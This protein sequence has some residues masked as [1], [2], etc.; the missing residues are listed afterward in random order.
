[1]GMKLCPS[2]GSDIEK[3]DNKNMLAVGTILNNRYELGTV[4]SCDNVSVIYIGY[5]RQA[6]I[7]VTLREFDGRAVEGCPDNNNIPVTGEMAVRRFVQY[8]R[9]MA[10]VSLC[11][12]FSRTVEVFE[13]N[14]KGYWVNE[15][16]EGTPLKEILGSDIKISLS[17]AVKITKELCDGLKILHFSHHIFGAI[18]PSSLY[19]QK[20]G[21]VKLFG[22][23]TPYFDFLSDFD[24]KATLLNPSYTAPEV[25]EANSKKGAFTDTYSVAAILYRIVTDSI[26]P[27]SFLR[28]QRESALIP[29]KVNKKISKSISNAILNAMCWDVSVRTKTPEAFYNNLK[30]GRVKRAYSISVLFACAAGRVLNM[31]D[32][33]CALIKHAPAE[34]RSGEELAEG[35]GIQKPSQAKKAFIKRPTG[36]ISMICAG[37]LVLSG[38]WFLCSR[39]IDNS[40][41]VVK[42]ND[43]Q[44]TVAGLDPNE[45]PYYKTMKS[46]SEKR[47]SKNNKSSSG[48]ES[49]V[50]SLICPDFTGLAQAEALK[51][52]EESGLEVGQIT[53]KEGS[54]KEETVLSQSVPAGARVQKGKAISL[55]VCRSA[56][57]ATSS[58]YKLEWPVPGVVGFELRKAI[59]DMNNAG[60]LNISLVF[61]ESDEP[62]GT[63]TKQSVEKEQLY[64][65]SEKIILT[66]SGTECR[67]PNY[68]GKTGEQALAIKADLKIVFKDE[69]SR[70]VST[71]DAKKLTVINQS[72]ASDSEAYKGETIALTVRSSDSSEAF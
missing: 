3:A 24:A 63:V 19:I 16:F 18:S 59:D 50:E 47:K 29:K 45:I 14:K 62:V 32:S 21:D 56:S 25:F 67:V 51:L 46:S 53:Y 69:L 10:G 8:A 43:N 38:V 52:I 34:K 58:G 39:I 11:P 27:V 65:P 5:D 23:G 44:S 15:Y 17:N 64:S 42:K 57:H 20:N 48:A 35:A 12:L 68:I 7:K 70:I 22:V 28:M 31:R 61:K 36:I 54:Q 33:I 41:N 4:L 6:D 71:E 37:L 13:Q 49:A 55:V 72:I 66:V 2:C 40:G 9:S 1:M 30:S 60:F 26:P